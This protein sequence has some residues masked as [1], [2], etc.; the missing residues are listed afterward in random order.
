MTRAATNRRRLASAISQ[1][2]GALA[3]RL[4][5]GMN[6]LGNYQDNTGYMPVNSAYVLRDPSRWQP[7]VRLQGTGVYIVQH[8]V[9]PQLANTEPVGAFDPR[10]FRAAPP[11][12]SDPESLGSIQRAGGRCTGGLGE[13]ER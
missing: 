12:A 13:F 4:R 5:D 6:Q 7:G 3:G 2:R 9:T 1:G 10:Q 11:I 8:F